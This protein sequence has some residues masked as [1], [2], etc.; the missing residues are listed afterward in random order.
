MS[1][2]LRDVPR[3]AHADPV[4]LTLT[5][6]ELNKKGGPKQGLGVGTR[7][8]NCRRGV[9]VRKSMEGIL[10]VSYR[11]ILDD[12]SHLAT[13]PERSLTDNLT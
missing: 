12:M 5:R 3:I 7:P 10:Y 8:D 1:Y 9:R 2:F 13:V 6:N 4:K 11:L